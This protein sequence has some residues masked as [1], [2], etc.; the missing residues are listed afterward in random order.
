MDISKK[1]KQFA[2]VGMAGLMAMSACNEAPVKQARPVDALCA[3]RGVSFRLDDGKNQR[4][5]L[6]RPPLGSLD[7]VTVY[8][9]RKRDWDYWDRQDIE[10]RDPEFAALEKEYQQKILGL[11][12]DLDR[13][14]VY[15]Q[16]KQ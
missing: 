13:L 14:K 8:K 16:T 11:Y 15:L 4:Y 9:R 3:P 1:I 2:S 12:I 10:P 7:H 6:D 5:F